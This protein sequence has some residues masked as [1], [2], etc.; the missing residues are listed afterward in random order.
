VHPEEYKQNP[1]RAA[2]RS[3]EPYVDILDDA[4]RRRIND[5]I[6]AGQIF[7]ARRRL[8]SNVPI[9]W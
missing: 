7:G 3:S 8:F 4:V 6:D 1:R 5:M 9:E 2:R